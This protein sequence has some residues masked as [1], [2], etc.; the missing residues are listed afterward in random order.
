M[1]VPSDVAVSAPREVPDILNAR[2]TAR[3]GATTN[4][5]SADSLVVVPSPGIQTIP[6]TV[7]RRP[8]ETGAS[9]A[10]PR[11]QN[12]EAV[13]L[14]CETVN[15]DRFVTTAGQW[16]P[17]RECARWSADGVTW[18]RRTTVQTARAWTAGDVPEA[19]GHVLGFVGE[20]LLRCGNPRESR[21]ELAKQF[22]RMGC[23]HIVIL[24]ATLDVSP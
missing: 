21:E 1:T 17:Q 3:A 24:P 9:I 7:V 13:Q 15:G 5:A 10:D 20:Q 18:H 8:V 12:D 23:T 16:P 14:F 22:N 2:L 11:N 19:R 6:V 4:S